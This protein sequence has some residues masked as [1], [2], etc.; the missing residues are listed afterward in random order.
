[1]TEAEYRLLPGVDGLPLYDED[2]GRCEQLT[3]PNSSQYDTVTEARDVDEAESYIA[4]DS[5][6]FRGGIRY[7]DADGTRFVFAYFWRL[8]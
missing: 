8:R 1:M 4:D 7:G 3:R 6:E 2:D 5:L